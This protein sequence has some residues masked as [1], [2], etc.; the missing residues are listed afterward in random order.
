MPSAYSPVIRLGAQDNVLVARVGLAAGTRIEA[1]NLTV[2]AD[3]PPGHKIA[4]RFIRRGE[5]ILKEDA[6]IGFAAADTGPGS[7]VNSE[8]VRFEPLPEPAYEFSRDFRPVELLPREQRATFQGIVRENGDVATRNFIGVLVVGNCAATA[9]RK[10]ADW[11]DEERLAEFPN[12]DGVVPFVHEI[13]CGMEMTGEPMDLLRRTLSGFIRNPNIAAAV[14]MALGCERN[15]LKSFLEQEKLA[16]GPKL[17]TVTLQEVGGVRN[18]VEHAKQMIQEMLP[19]ANNVTRQTV[20]AEHL[21]VGLQSGGADAFSGLSA[22]PALGAAVDLLVRN[23]GTAILSETP[24]LTGMGHLLAARAASREV[25]EKLVGRLNWWKQYNAGKDTQLHGRVSRANQAGGI[26]NILEKS[27][28]SG[29]KAGSSPLMGVYRYAERV[30]DKGLVFM[31]TPAYEPVSVTGQIAGGATLIALTTGLGSSFGSL[32]APTMK[33]ASNS[34]LYE[35][36]EDDMDVNCGLVVDGEASIEEMG[37]A[38]FEQ[39]LR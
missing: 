31:D 21:R 36:M 14:V 5:P 32:P 15:N 37:R 27:L 33:L 22:D 19:E 9:A 35:R 11:F 8:I 1:E 20:S 25:G 16:V 28:G 6:V 30:T 13:G 10:A 29:K 17:R 2:A 23:G 26:V 4:A 24:E 39:L 3:V 12:V 34:A 18:A 7:H 38:I